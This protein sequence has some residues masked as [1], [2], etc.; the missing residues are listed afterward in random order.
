MAAGGEHGVREE[1]HQADAAAAVDELDISF[2]EKSAEG[3]GGEAVVGA[4]AGSGAAVDAEA[5]H[6]ME[7]R[8]PSVL[9]LASA[10]ATL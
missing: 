9:R 6:G 4:V 8:S 5:V 1:A 3:L 7:D 2:G 10:D